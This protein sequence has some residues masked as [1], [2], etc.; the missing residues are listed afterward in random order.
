MFTIPLEKSKL[1]LTNAE[2]H[3]IEHLI[4][5]PSS[6]LIYEEGKIEPGKLMAVGILLLEEKKSQM[7]LHIYHTCQK[8]SVELRDWGLDEFAVKND[9]CPMCNAKY[10]KSARF[11]IE[12]IIKYPMKLV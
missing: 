7:R 2:W 3:Y 10:N 1:K 12:I 9:S 5:E 6:T 11:D 4:K 8:D